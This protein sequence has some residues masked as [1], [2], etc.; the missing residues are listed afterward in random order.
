MTM[1]FN[2]SVDQ[3]D[4]STIVTDNGYDEAPT[5]LGDLVVAEI[6][7]QFI[8][9]DDWPSTQ[10]Q[11]TTIRD[12]EIRALVLPMIA[13]AVAKPIQRTNHFG[14]PA[15]EPVT[16]RDIVLEEARSLLQGLK[17][18]NIRGRNE[19]LVRQLVREMV[20]KELRKELA[21]IVKVEG[22]KV[23]TA[24]RNQAA[25]LI[26]EAVTKGVGGK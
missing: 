1:Q 22:E 21:E 10:R 26:A 4:L 14:E 17:E 12:E 3:V 15:G 13:D 23:K 2:V 9:S 18:T 7:R 6:A 24:V 8:K 19:P 5:T 25:E 11:I 16:L 20:E